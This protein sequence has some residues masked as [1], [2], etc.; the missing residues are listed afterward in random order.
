[1]PVVRTFVLCSLHDLYLY[2]TH[3]VR[4]RRVVV[5]VCVFFDDAHDDVCAAYV[6]VVDYDLY[7]L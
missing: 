5:C 2:V 6:L 7:H 3:G 1:M 4:A